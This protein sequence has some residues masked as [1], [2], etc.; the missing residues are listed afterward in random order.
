MQKNQR[1][2]VAVVTRTKDRG[3][4][5]E[6]A[7]KSVHQQTLTD[8]V[9]VIINDSGD[10]KVV[11]DL[12]AKYEGIINGRVKVIHNDVSHGM[13]AASNKAIKS[14]DSEYVAIHDDDDSWH[15]RFLE[16][17]TTHMDTTGIKG[18]IARTERVY[19]SVIGDTV[20]VLSRDDYMPHLS[21][22]A[23]FDL[24][25]ENFAV[26]IS[27]LYRREVYDTVGYYN[28]EL[29]VTGDWDFALRFMRYFD[30]DKV[31][32]GYSLAFYHIRPTNNGVMG[33]SIFDPSKAHVQY[34]TML[35]NRFL[36]EDLDKGALGF[37]YLFNVANS[38]RARGWELDEIQ[39]RVSELSDKID[40]QAQLIEESRFSFRK[41]KASVRGKVKNVA[42]K[43][44]DKIRG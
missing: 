29:K 17:L 5:L 28:E 9:H 20:K 14:V 11:D 6:R 42:K 1:F 18:A 16:A 41:A 12:V 15:P 43:I 22:L 24:F 35:A 2:K 8:L 4:L 36:R 7:I 40:A 30:I 34:H 38:E 10:K 19:E 44:R 37:G 13:E 23:L 33:N 31:D 26:P 3:V 32:P 27:F 25:A 21:H 39:Q